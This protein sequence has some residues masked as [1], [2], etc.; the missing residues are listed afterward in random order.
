MREQGI[1]PDSN[2]AI[3]VLFPVQILKQRLG[4]LALPCIEQPR[5][6]IRW[7]RSKLLS[8][9]RSC[10]DH[11]RIIL[12]RGTQKIGPGQSQRSMLFFS[13]GDRH[14][15]PSGDLIIAAAID[16]AEAVE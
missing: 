12:W 10:Q 16:D 15:T 14:A 9:L 1:V 7:F 4:H 6:Q 8:K 5:N 11:A 13:I 2:I 3:K